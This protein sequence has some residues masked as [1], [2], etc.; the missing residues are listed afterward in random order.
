MT[1]SVRSTYGTATSVC[2]P[3]TVT[4][5]NSSTP[6]PPGGGGAAGAPPDTSLSARLKKK[7]H[8]ATFTFGSPDTSATF[9]CKLDKAALAACTS[10]KT[11]KKL[12]KGRHTFMV[13]AMNAAGP[14]PSPATFSFKLKR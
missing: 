11:Y 6:P 14:D 3:T 12:R 2:S 1:F 8:K 13:E 7:K 5:T 4:Y 10:P 9:R